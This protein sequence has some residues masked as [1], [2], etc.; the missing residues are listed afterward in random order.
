M[1]LGF[2]HKH[3]SVC[4][5][6]HNRPHLELS[7]FGRYNP[8]LSSPPRHRLS[9][10][11]SSLS[12]AFASSRFWS[13]RQG[14]HFVLCTPSLDRHVESRSR[15]FWR[16]AEGS[17][18]SWKAHLDHTVS[19]SFLFVFWNILRHRCCELTLF[20]WEAFSSPPMHCPA[21]QVC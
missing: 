9:Y 2:L 13:S 15:M 20:V 11:W 12:F 10:V 21:C 3:W 17:L 1:S 18:R 16:I 4:H 6:L 8:P 19:T 5:A 14:R 7:I